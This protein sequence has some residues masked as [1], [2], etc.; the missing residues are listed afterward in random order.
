[1]VEQLPE[2]RGGP[3]PPGLFPVDGVQSLVNE[4]PDNLKQEGPARYCLSESVVVGD[5]NHDAS[6]HE[7][8]PRESK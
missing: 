4:N 3:S 6:E 7:S 1:M 2:R 5:G 8:E